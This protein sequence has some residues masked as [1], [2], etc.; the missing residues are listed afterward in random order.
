M[1]AIGGETT[2]FVLLN[3]KK[4]LEVS[5]PQAVIKNFS[6]WD[7]KEVT[8][9]GKTIIIKGIERGQRRVFKASSI[10]IKG[11]GHIKLKVNSNKK[12]QLNVVSRVLKFFG[13]D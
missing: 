8:L 10:Q 2:G 3:D 7:G 6:D 11:E 13:F 12:S 5:L 1:M 9:K 4:R